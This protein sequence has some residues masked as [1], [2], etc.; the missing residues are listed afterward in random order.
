MTRP[1]ITKLVSLLTLAIVGLVSA[2]A[3]ADQYDHIDRY[4]LKIQNKTRI[5]LSETVHY[6]HTPQYS[7]L[8]AC[9]NELNRLATHIHDV[10]HFEGNLTH[11]RSDLR[12]LDHEFHALEDL[13]DRVEVGASRGYGHIYGRTAHVK[14]L[15]NSIEDCIHHIQDDVDILARASARVIVTQPVVVSRPIVVNR[16]I[17][18]TRSS[19]PTQSVFAPSR[20]IRT[21]PVYVPTPRPSVNFTFSTRGNGNRGYGGYG[22]AGHGNSRG[23]GY[24]RGNSGRGG[25]S[26]GG[27]DANRGSGITIGGGSSQ[28]RIRF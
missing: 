21:S 20:T 17:A 5:L 8:V 15:L 1:T 6:R 22:N 9:T 19:C 4:A 3:N 24:S 27:R 23:N 25:H 16:P 26:H 10:T 12:E 14:D 18:V 7:Q 13:F 11:L 28:I 2:Q